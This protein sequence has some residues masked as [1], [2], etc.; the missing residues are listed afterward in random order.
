[1]L[2]EFRPSFIFLGKFL[3]IYLIGNI[4]YGL[5][6]ESYGDRA[7]SI[8]RW[9]TH[10]TCSVLKATG[11]ATEAVPNDHGPTIF[12]R[13]D[14]HSVLNVFEGCNGV[15]VMII[16]VAFLFAFGGPPKKMLWFLPLGLVIIHV[17]NLLRISLLYF[18]AQRYAQYFY[19]VHKYFFTAI[20]YFII[21]AL[22]AIW[23][24]RFNVRP[25]QISTSP[26]PDNG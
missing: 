25:G 20:L 23:V 13:E 22:W 24:I 5:Y 6:V 11:A 19:F 16:F 3:G 10:Q 12:L 1:M 2:K 4:I 15:N 18:T 14:H 7:D 8:T 17:S 21:F 26:E 9:V